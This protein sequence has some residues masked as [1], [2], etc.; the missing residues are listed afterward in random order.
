[1]AKQNVKTLHLQF[2]DKAAHVSEALPLFRQARL[3]ASQLA[4]KPEAS[5]MASLMAWEVLNVV[6][7]P[8]DV[9]SPNL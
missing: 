5:I 1:L 9:L 6:G 4:D 3:A 8:P 2:R 7:T